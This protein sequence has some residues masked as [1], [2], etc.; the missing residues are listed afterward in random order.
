M[1]SFRLGRRAAL[2]ALALAIAAALAV[3]PAGSASAENPPP[4]CAPGQLP[5]T[6]G[7]SVSSAPARRANIDPM[8]ST[9]TV[10][11]ASRHH[12]ANKSRLFPSRSVSVSRL[13]PPFDVAPILAISIRLD[14]SR[15][16]LMRRFVSAAMHVPL[17]YSRIG[18]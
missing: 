11:P 4:A 18:A 9:D 6:E 16:P 1:I 17:S 10:H 15:L 5:T 7:G 8:A 3:V 13:T 12:V 14:Q 2:C